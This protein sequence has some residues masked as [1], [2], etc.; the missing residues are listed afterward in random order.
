MGK[1]KAKKAK[2]SKKDA[3]TKKNSKKST[4]QSKKSSKKSEKREFNPRAH[5]LVPKHEILGEEETEQLYERYDIDPTN[6]PTIL[7][8]DAA[9]KG[10]DVKLGDV[11]KITRKSATAGTSTFYR[12]VA[13]E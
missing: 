9:L 11:I 1:E 10:L 2:A 7:G 12:R 13:Y 5:E 8:S 4:K 6:L 3:K